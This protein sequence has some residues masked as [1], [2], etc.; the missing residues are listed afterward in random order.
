MTDMPRDIN[1]AQQLIFELMKLSSFN[2]FDGEK[3]V[4]SL[5]KHRDLWDGAMMSQESGVDIEVRDIKDGHWNVSTLWLR[6][7][8]GSDEALEKLARRWGADEVYWAPTTGCFPMTRV[9]KVWW[10]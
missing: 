3:V 10:D 4:R 2:D 9:L 7:S 6:P 1:R 8:S 5:E